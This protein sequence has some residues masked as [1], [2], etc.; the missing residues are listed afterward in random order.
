MTFPAPPIDPPYLTADSRVH[1]AADRAKAVRGMSVAHLDLLFTLTAGRPVD[2]ERADSAGGGLGRDTPLGSTA[3][4]ISDVHHALHAPVSVCDNVH[5]CRHAARVGVLAAL[6]FDVYTAVDLRALGACV[7][8]VEAPPEGAAWELF[9]DHQ[10]RASNRRFVV[11]VLQQA[12]AAAATHGYVDAGTLDALWELAA[13]IAAVA[14]D[15]VVAAA[16]LAPA[17]AGTPQEL[18]AVAAGV[19]A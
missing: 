17:W 3:S 2:T 14:P 10:V 4:Q 13:E 15:A 12:C 8:S 7:A 5:G 19:T 9:V 11:R 6:C 16:A 18:L 1:R